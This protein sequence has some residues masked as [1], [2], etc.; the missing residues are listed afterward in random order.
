[1]KQWLETRQVL[2]RLAELL[3]EGKR[4]ALGTAIIWWDVPRPRAWR[5]HE[6][7]QLHQLCP[8][9]SCPGDAD[10]DSARFRPPRR[11][12]GPS[13]LRGLLPP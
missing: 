9:P 4:A 12:V 2:D 10:S 5:R 7:P 6:R 8:I 11:T 3:T 13:P 1:M